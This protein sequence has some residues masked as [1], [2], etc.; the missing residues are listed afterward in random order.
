MAYVSLGT[1]GRSDLLPMV[2]R[3]LDNLGVGALV[4]TAGRISPAAIP[5][6]TWVSRFLPGLKAAARADFVICNGGSATVYQAFAAGVPVLGIPSNLDQYLMMAYVQRSGA[7]GYLRAGDI[8]VPSLTR[9]AD[10]MLHRSTYRH[11]AGRLGSLIRSGHLA[12]RFE[13]LLTPFLDPESSAPSA[14]FPTNPNTVPTHVGA[15]N[16]EAP[17]HHDESQR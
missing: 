10:L 8:S 7:G 13:H 9:L 5:D 12:E 4:S 3:A 1:S 15:G 2:L 11:Q 16:P 14:T 17:H 6:R